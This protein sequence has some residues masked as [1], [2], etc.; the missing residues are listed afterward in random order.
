MRKVQNAEKREADDEPVKP[1]GDR[2]TSA[3]INDEDDVPIESLTLRKRHAAE[4]REL[5]AQWSMRLKEYE[6]QNKFL[7]YSTTKRLADDL[8][9]IE[10]KYMSRRRY[11]LPCKGV[12]SDLELCLTR[13]KSAPLKCSQMVKQ[14]D[15]CVKEARFNALLSQK[16]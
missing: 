2:K 5:Q 7:W 10:H 4:I 3:T 1:R 15:A 11:E 14:F 9:K 6:D 13:N 12:E 8:G 16:S